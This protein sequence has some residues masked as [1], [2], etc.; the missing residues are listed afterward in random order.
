MLEVALC[1]PEALQTLPHS[2]E[3][4][5]PSTVCVRRWSGSDNWGFEPIIPTNDMVGHSWGGHAD[6]ARVS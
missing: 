2:Y 5:A 4:G 3:F 1:L 6:L